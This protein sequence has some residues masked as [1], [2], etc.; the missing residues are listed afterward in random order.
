[1]QTFFCKLIAP[2][3]TFAMDMNE[4]EAQLMNE[5]A[6]YWRSWMEKGNVVAFGLVADPAGPYGIGIIEVEDAAA[7][8][9]LTD[10]DPTIRSGRGFSYDVQP[11]PFGAVHPRAALPE[12]G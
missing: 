10:N 5:H 11:M 1:M 9:N 2:R 4:A 8:R 7:A 12:G 3:P 6:G